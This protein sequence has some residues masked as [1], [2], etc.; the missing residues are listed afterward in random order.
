MNIDEAVASIGADT[1]L[2]VL[3]SGHAQDAGHPDSLR[4]RATAA[5]IRGDVLGSLAWSVLAAV[6]WEADLRMACKS[7]EQLEDACL[8]GSGR[9]FCEMK[10]RG[11]PLPQ[12]YA[13]LPARL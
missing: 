8:D 2:S 9:A 10:R 12:S 4:G 11:L 7:P 6:R 5:A 13:L 3:N 1:V